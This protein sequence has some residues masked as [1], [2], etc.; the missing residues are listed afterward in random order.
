MNNKLTFN[1]TTYEFNY[2]EGRDSQTGG[3]FPCYGVYINGALTTSYHLEEG[4]ISSGCGDCK[5][6]QLCWILYYKSFATGITIDDFSFSEIVKVINYI[7][8]NE[9]NK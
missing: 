9:K 5:K 1:E 3:T 2:F 7:I 8:N 6:V 4:T